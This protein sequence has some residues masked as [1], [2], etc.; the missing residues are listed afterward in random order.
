MILTHAIFNLFTALSSWDF[1]GRRG[2]ILELSIHSPC[3]TKHFFKN[4]TIHA[5]EWTGDECFEDEDESRALLARTPIAWDT[6]HGW[7]DGRQ[8]IPVR[9]DSLDR[10]AFEDAKRKLLGTP[11]Q[12][13]VVAD[14]ELPSVNVILGFIVRRQFHRRLAPDALGRILRAL[15]ALRSMQYEF[16]C[17][18]TIETIPL[19]MERLTGKVFDLSSRHASLLL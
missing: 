9:P 19:A 11:L 18:T 7:E 14:K 16:W 10:K 6:H 8:V 3:D 15:P 17:P 2:I 13:V 4:R 1:I 5:V 12:I